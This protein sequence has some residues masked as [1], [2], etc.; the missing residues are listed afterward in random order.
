METKNG[1]PVCRA[2]GRT[3]VGVEPEASISGSILGDESTDCY[4]VCPE[5]RAYT[6]AHWWEP[7][8]GPEN[9]SLSGPLPEAEGRR[10][11]ANIRACSEPWDK[12]CRC[13]AHRAHFGDSLD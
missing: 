11:V 13:P 8:C 10:I 2:C 1:I 12:T 9:M 4:Y 7:F 5:C 3:L 6:V